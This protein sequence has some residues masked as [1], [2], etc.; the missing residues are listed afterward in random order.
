MS[1]FYSI[2]EL[3][4]IGLRAFGENV[5][6]SRKTSIYNPEKISIGN[7]V[8]IDDF[9]ILSGQIVLGSNIHISAYVALYGA[10]GIELQDYT[11]ISPKS[12]L[13]SAMDDFCGDY[14]IGPIHNTNNT[15]V[16]GGK[17]TM[18]K[19]SQIGSGCV[20]FPNINIGQGCVIGAMSLI[21][22]NCD[23]WSIYIGIPARKIKMRSR[24]LLNLISND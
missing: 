23:S 6:I 22:R 2:E 18:E 16:K 20:I 14:L 4:E 12:V 9:C 17:I 8:R 7:N 10:L 5:F 24:K 1:S 13:F 11:G 3:K 21:N 15:N 19:Y